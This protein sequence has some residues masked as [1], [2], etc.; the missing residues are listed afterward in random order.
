VPDISL[1]TMW[2]GERF[3]T[4]RD[5]FLVAANLGF[6]SFELT[7]VVG[8]AFYD[9]IHPGEFTILS[10]HDP[11]PGDLDSA[12]LRASDIVFTSLDEEKRTMAV[13][14]TKRSI[15]TA[16]RYGAQAVVLHLGHSEA[17]TQWQAQLEIL[18]RAG[19]IETTEADIIRA[20]LANE[21]EYRH[22]EHMAALMRSLDE[23]I[24]YAAARGIRLG[25]ENRRHIHQIPNFEEMWQLLTAYPDETIGYW[26]DVGHAE[27]QAAVGMTPHADWLSAFASR[28]V[29]LHLHDCIGFQ[30]H[31]APGSGSVR[32]QDLS[33]LVPQRGIRTAEIKP[34]VSEDAIRCGIDH[35]LS[36][37]WVGA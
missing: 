32:W 29:G 21:R 37:G 35:L 25:I 1:S 8:P 14:V 3:T 13:N 16:V 11:A 22:Q 36:V 34:N 26:H 6:R 10:L 20:R 2:M 24:P 28:L 23:V 18:A 17:D 27:L 30:D 15:D 7:P 9:D 12:T 4:P 33:R 5:F 31:Q 19:R